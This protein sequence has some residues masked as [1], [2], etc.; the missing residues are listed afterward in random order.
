MRGS[1]KQILLKILNALSTRSTP[2]AERSAAT[3]ALRAGLLLHGSTADENLAAVS[4][5]EWAS[6]RDAE[7]T[8][9][10]QGIA[11]VGGQVFLADIAESLADAPGLRAY[12]LAEHP[13]LTTASLDAALHALW[14]ITSATQM[15][16]QLLSVEAPDAELDIPHAIRVMA[17]HFDA[18][19]LGQTTP[20]EPPHGPP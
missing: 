4:R 13:A 5:L 14:L 1:G 8:L 19:Q 12:L 15:Y 6:A 16:T 7:H 2:E 11:T 17:R 10:R 20:P 18:Y 9:W 3:Q